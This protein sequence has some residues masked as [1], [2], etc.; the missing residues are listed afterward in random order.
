MEYKMIRPFLLVAWLL[1]IF[2]F[3]ND[4]V[5]AKRLGSGK[6]VGTQRSATTN[7][8][9]TATNT[10][11]P[12]APVAAPAPAAKP[13]SWLG[14]MAGLAA[15]LGLGWLLGHSGLLGDMGGMSGMIGALLMG[16]LAAGV[17]MLLIRLWRSR[18]ASPT[19]QYT[20]AESS[21]NYQ[22]RVSEST[23]GIAGVQIGSHA[24][25]GRSAPV[26]ADNTIPADFDVEGFIKQAKMNFLHLQEANDRGDTD[27]LHDVTTS[28]MF[29]ALKPEV[30][31][32]GAE[33]VKTGGHTEVISLSASLME[34]TTEAGLYWASVRFAGQIREPQ[35][36][37]AEAFEE[38][39]HLQKSVSGD[40]GWVLAGIQQVS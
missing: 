38:I 6:D 28:E 33:N 8:N 35:A 25:L 22:S 12:A 9:N 29:A 19:L 30:L 1:V 26:S 27:M 40:S 24:G 17:V 37:R 7:Q 11:K 5:S 18:S 20:P 15:G 31:A 2:G 21:D 13:S 34:V 16:L 3:V 23:G 36:T 39:W 10:T 4:A 14:P 32:N